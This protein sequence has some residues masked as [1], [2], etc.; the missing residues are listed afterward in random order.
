MRKELRRDVTNAEIAARLGLGHK[1]VKPHIARM[2]SKLGLLGRELTR[3]PIDNSHQMTTALGKCGA[4]F[5]TPS[6]LRRY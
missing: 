4:H 3:S 5:G 2:L 1:T 6:S